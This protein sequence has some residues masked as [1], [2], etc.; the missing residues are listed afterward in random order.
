MQPLIRFL[1]LAIAAGALTAACTP[2]L[3]TRGNLVTA[4]QMAQLTPQKTTRTEVLSLLGTPTAKAPLDDSIWIYVGE[5]TQGRTFRHDAV[6]ARMV[7]ELTFDANGV[8][9][10]IVTKDETAASDDDVVML[11]RT[12]PTAGAQ[13]NAVQQFVGNV[14]RFNKKKAQ[15]KK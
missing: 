4:E 12:T 2:V 15:E 5:E 14:G 11:K 9:Q 13:M 10:T 8:L 3:H 6:A 1:V 7:T